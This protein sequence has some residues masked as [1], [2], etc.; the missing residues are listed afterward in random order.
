MYRVNAHPI[1][2]PYPL[3]RGK[4]NSFFLIFQYLNAFFCIELYDFPFIPDLCLTAN[5][6]DLLIIAIKSRA[7]KTRHGSSS[8]H[9]GRGSTGRK[10][11]KLWG[12]WCFFGF[13]PLHP[14]P[15]EQPPETARQGF[16]LLPG[17]RSLGP[18]N[19]SGNCLYLLPCR[20]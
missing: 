20:W 12:D 3:T 8:N 18:G 5:L 1:H 14:G 9:R 2:A 17:H 11:L 13:R 7:A 19:I 6:Y 15:P 16:G 4:T 10:G